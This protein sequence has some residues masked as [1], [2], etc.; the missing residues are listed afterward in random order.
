MKASDSAAVPGGLQ[1]RQITVAN[2]EE[3]WASTEVELR[4]DESSFGGVVRNGPEW[5]VGSVVD[6]V[7]DFRDGLG[8]SYQ[9]RATGQVVQGAF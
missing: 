5:G 4:S 7:I 6:V 8:E 9:L 1:A 3:V 2:G